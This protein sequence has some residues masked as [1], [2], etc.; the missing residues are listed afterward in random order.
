MAVVRPG[1]GWHLELTYETGA[2]TAP[3][4]TE[5]D[6]V[7]VCLDESSVS[8]SGSPRKSS[9]AWKPTAASG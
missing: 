9:P 1:A 6:L 4:P 3:T 2:P 7:V 5:E 8:T